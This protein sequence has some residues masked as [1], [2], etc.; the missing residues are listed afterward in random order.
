MMTRPLPALTLTFALSLAVGAHAVE[1]AEYPQAR[2]AAL[3]LVQ[4]KQYDQA[5]EAFLKLANEAQI[6]SHK[7]DAL[8]QAAMVANATKDN[9]RAMELAK[10]IP[11]PQVSKM[12]QMRLL[13]SQKEYNA[14]LE[15]AGQ[16]DLTQWVDVVA[17]EALY[18]RGKAHE[19]TRSFYQAAADYESALKVLGQHQLRAEV[20]LALA[21]L[22]DTKLD[23][24]E[25]AIETYKAVQEVEGKRSVYVWTYITAVIGQ[26]QVQAK[27][28]D[29]DAALATL[30]Q[31]DHTDRTGHWGA[32]IRIAK[33]QVHQQRNEK[34]EALAL[35]K[36]ALEVPKLPTYLKPRIEKQ[37]QELE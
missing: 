3:K 31:L 29:T 28:G 14:V 12:V 25:K 33:A 22:Y 4:K 9:A 24:P 35:L 5:M 6:L 16:E 34:Q 8:E 17:G 1:P 20:G 2:E 23:Q 11:D 27:Q 30:A 7:T 15:L 19:A 37:I 26:A 32:T 21:Q 10:E 13:S 18:Y 36:E